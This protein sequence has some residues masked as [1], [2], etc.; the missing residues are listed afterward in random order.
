LAPME[1]RTVSLRPPP[2]S[3]GEAKRLRLEP[4]MSGDVWW[5][6]R[7]F[8]TTR[9]RTSARACLMRTRGRA[10]YYPARV[11]PDDQSA[12]LAQ[13]PL[14]ASSGQTPNPRFPQ[15]RP[16]PRFLEDPP[17]TVQDPQD[18]AKPLPRS[19]RHPRNGESSP[20]D[21]YF[22]AQLPCFLPPTIYQESFRARWYHEASSMELSFGDPRLAQF[23]AAAAASTSQRLRTF[24]RPLA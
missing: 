17:K 4:F 2:N 14:L 24:N 16:T 5:R 10:R 15:I 21:R 12:H 9:T 20:R 6:S 22:F 7:A 8:P 3:S 11:G 19:T 13:S 1:L 23:V 18:P